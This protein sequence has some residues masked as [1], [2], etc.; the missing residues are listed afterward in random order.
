MLKIIVTRGASGRGYLPGEDSGNVTR[1]VD[2][3]DWPSGVSWSAPQGVRRLHVCSVRLAVNPL[4][5]GIKHLN[6]LEQVMATMECHEHGCD[7][8]VMLDTNDFVI[9][10]T[11]SNVFIVRDNRLYTPDLQYSGVNG[12]VRELLIEDVINHGIPVTVTK[13]ML[14]DLE[15]ADEV[16]I[17]NSVI[18]IRPVLAVNDHSISATAVTTSIGQQLTRFMTG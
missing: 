4:L 15:S 7:E 2:V 14:A 1:I 10:G 18:G 17:S 16:F 11:R 12:I 3:F 13:L 6:R 9:E 5:A 8:G